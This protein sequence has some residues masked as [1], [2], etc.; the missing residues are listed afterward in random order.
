MPGGKAVVYSGLLTITPKWGGLAIVL[1]H[2]IT[3]AIVRTVK[4]VRG[5]LQQLGGSAL[6]FAPANK[7]QGKLKIYFLAYG[8]GSSVGALLPFQE[9][10]S[11][12]RWI[13]SLLCSHG[14]LQSPGSCSWGEN[15]SSR[16]AQTYWISEWS[17]IWCKT[18][19]ENKG[20]Y[21]K[22]FKVLQAQKLNPEDCKDCPII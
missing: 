6:S 1:G 13:R 17:S 15:G 18:N 12:S 14:G 4:V 9:G 8:V 20:I 22:G 7:T 3:H 5:L 16:R 19:C 2:E 10:R 11:W 21:A